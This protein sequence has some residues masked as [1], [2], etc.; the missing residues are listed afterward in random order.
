MVCIKTFVRYLLVF[1]PTYLCIRLHLDLSSLLVRLQFSTLLKGSYNVFFVIYKLLSHISHRTEI[2]LLFI[3]M[4][5]HNNVHQL[6]S[7]YSYNSIQTSHTQTC[8]LYWTF[9]EW[10]CMP[11]LYSWLANDRQTIL[12]CLTDLL[13]AAL[14]PILYI[15]S[16]NWTHPCYLWIRDCFLTIMSNLYLLTLLYIRY[17]YF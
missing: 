6:R 1:L 13:N 11:H 10:I 12:W 5:V 7:W 4:Q 3:E 9:K 15:S 16:T 17:I 8:A 2:S 14:S